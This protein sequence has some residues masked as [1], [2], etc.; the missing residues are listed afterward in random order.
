MLKKK[1]EGQV[2]SA[3]RFKTLKSAK[4]WKVRLYEKMENRHS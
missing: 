1:A 2:K 3:T 4:I